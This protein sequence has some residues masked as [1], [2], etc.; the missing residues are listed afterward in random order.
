MKNVKEDIMVHAMQ[1]IGKSDGGYWVGLYNGLVEKYGLKFPRGY[2]P[3]KGDSWCAIFI[4]ALMLDAGV[5][6]FPIEVGAQRLID[7]F[8]LYYTYIPQDYSR[9]FII[10]YDWQKKGGWIDHVGLGILH[11]QDENSLF[12]LEGNY[13]GGVGVRKISADSKCIARIIDL[14]KWLEMR[15]YNV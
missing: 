3:S 12:S 13:N 6:D 15:G 5:K 1:F 8:D 10:G 14:H 7:N 4:S 2:K 11:N 9:L